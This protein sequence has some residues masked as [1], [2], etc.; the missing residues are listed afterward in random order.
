M[1]LNL[2]VAAQSG[3]LTVSIEI[4]GLEDVTIEPSV[5]PVT[6]EPRAFEL[7]FRERTD[8][9]M[10][11]GVID[12]LTVETGD[13]TEVWLSLE[14]T[15]G[16]SLVDDEAVLVTLVPDSADIAANEAARVMLSA[17]QPSTIVTLEVGDDASSASVFATIE[18][19]SVN[20][21]LPLPNVEPS[22]DSL[23]AELSVTVPRRQFRL[24]FDPS[25]VTLKS[26]D[27][28]NLDISI[29]ALDAESA[30]VAGES[31]NVIFAYNG[32]PITPPQP[33]ILT[34][35]EL[36]VPVSNLQLNSIESGTLTASA[37]LAG[38]DIAEG[39]VGITIER[40]EFR[41]SFTPSVVTVRGGNAFDVVLSLET[42]AG[43]L[44]DGDVV[45][46]TL[47]SDNTAQVW[48][49]DA[50]I[51]LVRDPLNPV[52]ELT[53]MIRVNTSPQVE[54][55]RDIVQF[56]AE[57]I[58][59]GGIFESIP[60][61]VNIDKRE[62]NIAFSPADRLT[63]EAS[64]SANLGLTLS[65]VGGSQLFD[66][67]VTARLSVQDSNGAVIETIVVEPDR[68][69]LALDSAREFTINVPADIE[70]GIGNRFALHVG[71]RNIATN[72]LIEGM[73]I[74]GD[75]ESV[76]I[77]SPFDV[78]W[79]NLPVFEVNRSM[80]NLVFNPMTV[81]VE[82]GGGTE[83]VIVSLSDVSLANGREVTVDFTL[84]LAMGV[85]V[86]TATD[87]DLNDDQI[88]VVLNESQPTAEVTIGA[89]ST[90]TDPHN[91]LIT[92]SVS[93]EAIQALNSLI[94][95]GA[96]QVTVSSSSPPI[97]AGFNSV[98]NPN[99]LS[100]TAGEVE[101]ISLSLEGVTPPL[102][103]PVT[104]SLQISGAD[105]AV[106]RR[107]VSLSANQVVFE[108]D[109]TTAMFDLITQTG[110]QEQSFLIT[111]VADNVGVPISTL[112]VS[113]QLRNFELAFEPQSVEIIAGD[114]TEV[115]LLLSQSL[116]AGESVT[117]VLTVDDIGVRVIPE[118]VVIVG[119]GDPAIPVQ[120]F[121]DSVKQ[122]SGQY[123]VSAEVI[124]DSAEAVSGRFTSRDLPVQVNKRNID[125]MFNSE[126][127]R[128]VRGGVAP[129]SVTMSVVIESVPSLLNASLLEGSETVQAR[130][131]IGS[132]SGLTVTP[133]NVGLSE[134]IP[135]ATVAITADLNSISGVVNV[136][137]G[138]NDNLRNV[139][140]CGMEELCDSLDVE[141]V[142]AVFLQFGIII[143]GERTD[144]LP[145]PSARS[146]ISL[147]EPVE[148]V[149]S[150]GN[151]IATW[152]GDSSRVLAQQQQEIPHRVVQASETAGVYIVA[153]PPLM[154]TESITLIV[155]LS[156][157][158]SIGDAE[159]ARQRLLSGEAI[160]TTVQVTL[161]AMM[162]ETTVEFT[163]IDPDEDSGTVTARVI[164]ADNVAVTNPDGTGGPLEFTLLTLETTPADE[165]ELLFVPSSPLFSLS[166]G[167]S[168]L[169]TVRSFPAL[170]GDQSILATLTLRDSNGLNLVDNVTTQVS[171]VLNASN[172]TEEVNVIAGLSAETSLIYVEVQSNGIDVQLRSSVFETEAMASSNSQ[173]IDVSA[174]SAF[175]V[176][177]NRDLNL[178]FSSE[179]ADSL[180]RLVVPRGSSRV[181]V[182]S[183]EGGRLLN[184]EQLPVTLAADLSG[185]KV[186]IDKD[187]LQD[188]VFTPAMMST[189]I[190]ITAALDATA[191]DAPVELTA[192]F[193]ALQANIDD[194]IQTSLGG[195]AIL[196][197]QPG[198]R[199]F[200]LILE[201]HNIA[202]DA[203][204]GDRR[205]MV[206][207][208]VTETITLLL[209]GSDGA[210][211]ESGEEVEVSLTLA[212]MAGI[213]L[214]GMVEVMPSPIIFNQDQTSAEV[215]IKVYEPQ[216]LLLTAEVIDQ[217]MLP[218]DVQ[219]N[220][221]TLNVMVQRGV[222][223]RFS[224]QP[225]DIQQGDSAILM[226]MIDPI[227]LLKPSNP[228]AVFKPRVSVTLQD[229]V[230][231]R[232]WV[233]RP[234]EV[235][236]MRHRFRLLDAVHFEYPTAA[237]PM[238]IWAAR[239]AM[240]GE[241]V[242][243]ADM[244]AEEGPFAGLFSDRVSGIVRYERPI[245][246]I[247]LVRVVTP[248]TTV[249]VDGDRDIRE[250]ILVKD[251]PREVLLS[252]SFELTGSQTATLD[253]NIEGS[254]LEVSPSVVMFS[255][256]NK[257]STVIMLATE[258]NFSDGISGVLTI[259]ATSGVDLEDDGRFD[260]QVLPQATVVFNPS[261]ITLI[262]GSSP[263]ATVQVATDP[264]L[265][266]VGRQ[267][268]ELLLDVSGV[269]GL[270]LSEDTAVDAIKATTITVTLDA[271][272]TAVNVALHVARYI[273]P[274]T[275]M[276]T[277]E[278]LGEIIDIADGKDIVAGDGLRADLVRPTF[279]L[280]FNNGADSLAVTANSSAP[281][282]VGI[283]P[284]DG[285]PLRAGE[286]VEVRLS[287]GTASIGLTVSPE[288]I[289]FT[290]SRLDLMS[291]Y[292]SAAVEPR[293]SQLSEEV[294]LEADYK[295][296]DDELTAEVVLDEAMQVALNATFIPVTVPILI[297]PRPYVLEFDPT[298]ITL[299]AGVDVV[300]VVIS[301]VGEVPFDPNEGIDVLFTFQDAYGVDHPLNNPTLTENPIR[302]LDPLSGNNLN[303]LARLDHV[304]MQ[305]TIRLDAQLDA[306]SGTLT[307]EAGAGQ[308]SNA[309]FTVAELTVI[310][311]RIFNID[312]VSGDLG[313][314]TV[315]ADGG[316]V[317]E[318]TA[319]SS[320]PVWVVYDGA[321][322][323][324]DSEEVTI[325]LGV[326]NDSGVTISL[327]Q[328]TLSRNTP[329]VEVVLG[330]ELI[331]N[332]LNVALTL[333]LGSHNVDG[334][335]FILSSE[336]IAVQPREFEVVFTPDPLN[337]ISEHSNTVAVSLNALTGRGLVSGDE[338]TLSISIAGDDWT[339]SPLEVSLTQSNPDATLTISAGSRASGVAMLTVEVSQ[340]ELSDGTTALGAAGVVS[341]GLVEIAAPGVLT[342]NLSAR[343][344][345]M[346][347]EPMM[348]DLVRGSP[349]ENTR[350][351]TVSVCAVIL[352]SPTDECESM[353]RPALF[354]DEEITVALVGSSGIT[355]MP[356][357]FMF[358]QDIDNQTTTITVIAEDTVSASPTAEGSLSF[359]AINEVIGSA[360]SAEVVFGSPLIVRV[361]RGVELV[362]STTTNPLTVAAGETTA[363][364]ITT[365]PPLDIAESVTAVL[366]VNGE[367][368]YLIDPTNGATTS[369][370]V[371]LTSAS[372]TAVFQLRVGKPDITG[373]IIAE[374]S[375]AN[376]IGVGIINRN[377]SLGVEVTAPSTVTIVFH[378]SDTGFSLINPRASTTIFIPQG[379]AANAIVT[380]WALLSEVGTGNGAQAVQ[381]V[382]QDTLLSGGGRLQIRAIDD[383]METVG[384]SALLFLNVR[385]G[386]INHDYLRGRIDFPQSQLITIYA[387]RDVP[388]GPVDP[389]MHDP[390]SA[391]VT[392]MVNIDLAVLSPLR[393][394]IVTP[395]AVVFED[396]NNNEI[397]NVE[398]RFGQSMVVNL[399][400]DPP[401]QGREVLLTLA[402]EGVGLDSII[403]L[404]DDNG[405]QVSVLQRMTSDSRSSVRIVV[406][407]RQVPANSVMG[408]LTADGTGSEKRQIIN[409]PSELQLRVLEQVGIVFNPSAVNVIAGGESVTVDITTDALLENNESVELML[410]PPSGII[411]S[412]TVVTLNRDTQEAE[413]IVRADRSVIPASFTIVARADT[414]SPDTREVVVLDG[415]FD[416]VVGQA[417]FD[418]LFNDLAQSTISVIAGESTDVTVSIMGNGNLAAGE[419]V[420]VFL[421]DDINPSE[422]LDTNDT[423][424]LG[425]QASSNPIR[426]DGST[427]EMNVR[428]TVAPDHPNTNGEVVTVRVTIDSTDPHN[429]GGEPQFIDGVIRVAIVERPFTL[430][431]DQAAVSVR[432][433]NSVDVRLSLEGARLASGEAA[434]PVFTLDPPVPGVVPLAVPTTF[435]QASDPADIT[436]LTITL[437]IPADTNP[438]ETRVI[439]SLGNQA[440]LHLTQNIQAELTLTIDS[441]EF[442]LVFVP[443]DISVAASGSATAELRLDGDALSDSEVVEVDL[444]FVPPAE[445]LAIGTPDI[446]FR[447]NERIVSVEITATSATQSGQSYIL[448]ANISNAADLHIA[449]T[450]AVATIAVRP[451]FALSFASP[452]ELIS[453]GN[454]VVA[455]LSLA[456]PLS[457]VGGSLN[458]EFI[459]ETVAPLQVTV[460]PS[461][462]TFT[463]SSTRVDVELSATD[464]AMVQSVILR[465]RTATN[466]VFSDPSPSIRVVRGVDL[467]LANGRTMLIIEA[468]NP[469]TVDVMTQL[470]ES[471]Q[472][473]AL[474][475]AETVTVEL[476]A[477]SPLQ[478]LD[479]NMNP[480]TMKTVILSVAQQST[481][482][483]IFMNAPA[484]SGI[485][486]AVVIDQNDIAVVEGARG[487]ELRLPVESR[488]AAKIEVINIPA[489]PR[490]IAGDSLDITFTTQP[491]LAS[492]QGVGVTLF[493]RDLLG[494]T[495]NR[496]RD[497]GITN[498][499]AA[500]L[501]EVFLG[502][503]DF[504]G[505]IHT[506]STEL[507]IVSSS[508][509][510]R[511]LV[512]LL[513]RE[514]DTAGL[515]AVLTRGGVSYHTGTITEATLSEFQIE[516]IHAFEI[517]FNAPSLNLTAGS[518]VTM[519]ISLVG[520]NPLMPA[521]MVTARLSLNQQGSGVSIDQDRVVF[522]PGATMTEVTVSAS[523]DVL[524]S[525][526]ALTVAVAIN[527]LLNQPDQPEFTTIAPTE[528][529][530]I[531]TPR[532]FNLG[533]ELNPPTASTLIVTAYDS[534]RMDN[535]I[536][537]VRVS[538]V[539]SG[540]STFNTANNESVTI[541]FMSGNDQVK[542]LPMTSDCAADN[543][544]GYTVDFSAN[545]LDEIVQVCADEQLVPDQELTLQGVVRSG[546]VNL[547]INSAL[548]PLEV[549]AL[550]DFSINFVANPPPGKVRAGDIVTVGVSLEG[551][552]RDGTPAVLQ[553][554][555]QVTVTFVVQPPL[556]GVMLSTDKLG[557][558]SDSMDGQV[559]LSVIS[560]VR[561][562]FELR[563]ELNQSEV[564]LGYGAAL[565]DEDSMLWT[566][567][568]TLTQ[569]QI[570][571]AVVPTFEIELRKL[572]LMFDR[573]TLDL[574]EGESA[575]VGI[576][577]EGANLSA[578]EIIP[579]RFES[580]PRGAVTA[581]A[582]I[583]MTNAV[584]M[585][586]VSNEENLEGPAYNL[587]GLIDNILDETESLIASVETDPLVEPIRLTVTLKPR[588]FKLMFSELS[589]PIS[590]TRPVNV[591]LSLMSESVML[592]GRE[593]VSLLESGESVTVALSGIDT[594]AA[595][596]DAYIEVQPS[597][598]TL[599]G[600][601]TDA[602][603]SAELEL[604]VT[605]ADIRSVQLIAT[606]MDAVTEG[607]VYVAE[608]SLE[609]TPM[610]RVFV[611]KFMPSQ[612]VLTPASESSY[613]SVRLSLTPSDISLVGGEEVK[614][615][616]LNYVPAFN[617]LGLRIL[618][619]A[620][621]EIDPSELS[622]TPGMESMELKVVLMAATRTAITSSDLVR[623]SIEITEKTP[624]SLMVLTNEDSS[625][626]VNVV[627][628]DRQ[629]EFTSTFT[630][631][632]NTGMPRLSLRQGA[633]KTI[634][635]LSQGVATLVGDEEVVFGVSPASLAAL[636]SNNIRVVPTRSTVTAIS[637]AVFE[638]VAGQNASSEVLSFIVVSSKLTPD[639]DVLELSSISID[640]LEERIFGLSFNPLDSIDVVEGSSKQ[641]KVSLNGIDGSR[642]FEGEVVTARLTVVA[643]DLD[644]SSDVSLSV[645]E[646]VPFEVVNDFYELGLS[647][648]EPS[649]FVIVNAPSG[650][651]SATISA[652][653]V[654]SDEGVEFADANARIERSVLPITLAVNILEPGSD[655]NLVFTPPT[656]AIVIAGSTAEIAVAL[657][658]ID[659]SILRPGENVVIEARDSGLSG[660]S[661]TPDSI[662]LDSSN[663]SG[664]FTV[665]ATRDV[666]GI[667][668]PDFGVQISSTSLNVNL[669]SLPI[670]QVVPP[671]VQFRAQLTRHEDDL[672]SNDGLQLA[673]GSSATLIIS[674]IDVG[675]LNEGEVVTIAV[676]G[677]SGTIEI[678]NPLNQTRAN[679]MEF[680]LSRAS[681]EIDVPVYV[682]DTAPVGMVSL[683]VSGQSSNFIFR[684]VGTVPTIEIVEQRMFNIVI[685]PS[686]SGIEGIVE[687]SLEGLN[688]R[689]IGN[690][691]VEVILEADEEGKATTFEPPSLMFTSATIYRNVDI[692]VAANA[693]MNF[694]IRAKAVQMPANTLVEEGVFTVTVDR[695]IFVLAFRQATDVY[696]R[697]ETVNSVTTRAGDPVQ[698]LL[699]LEGAALADGEIVPVRVTAQPGQANINGEG[700]MSR[701]MLTA[702]YPSTVVT[703]NSAFDSGS[704]FE[705]EA[706]VESADIPDAL[707]AIPNSNIDAIQGTA[708][709]VNIER[710]FRLVFEPAA[711][712]VTAG[713]SAEVRLLLQLIEGNLAGDETVIVNLPTDNTQ[714]VWTNVSPITF[715][716][717]EM[718]TSITV[719][720]TRVVELGQPDAIFDS[721]PLDIPGVT[722]DLAHLA[723]NIVKREFEISF[724]P[725]DTLTVTAGS[726]ARLALTLNGVEGSQ[727]FDNERVTA[728][729]TVV[730]SEGNFVNVIIA[731]PE[732]SVSIP[733]GGGSTLEVLPLTL[734]VAGAFIIEAAVDAP[735]GMANSFKLAL[736][737]DDGS[738][739]IIDT[740]DVTP[741]SLP[742]LEVV[743][744]EFNLVFNLS[745]LIV[746]AG[747]SVPIE[748][749][750]E[751]GNSTSDLGADILAVTLSFN[752]VN[753][754]VVELTAASPSAEF[755][756]NI[757]A[758]AAMEGILTATAAALTNANITDT[759]LPVTIAG[760]AFALVFR[761]L[762][763]AE[764][765]DPQR[766]DQIVLR[767]GRSTQVWLSL[768]DADLLADESVTVTLTADESVTATSTADAIVF[769]PS[770]TSALV[771]I[772]ANLDATDAYVL[773]LIDTTDASMPIPP[774]ASFAD[775]RLDIDVLALAL[776]FDRAAVELTVDEETQ[777]ELSLIDVEG[778]ALARETT[779]TVQ[780]STLEGVLVSPETV[781]LSGE[782]PSV[783]ISLT[784]S[785][786][787][788]EGVLTA[789]VSAGADGVAIRDG[790]L[791]VGV[792]S[793]EFE[794]VFRSVS[795]TAREAAPLT[796]VDILAAGTT[797]VLLSLE[798]AEFADGE[799]VT[800]RVTSADGL[801]VPVDG[802]EVML[803]ATQTMVVVEL[804]AAFNAVN[805]T[806]TAAIDP[807]DYVPAGQFILPP[808]ANFAMATVDA[809]IAL[810][811][812]TLA[813]N[814]ST[815]LR[816][817]AGDSAVVRL[818]LQAVEGSMLGESMLGEGEQVSVDLTYQT[819]LVGGELSV[820]PSP[821]AVTLTSENLSA[822]II[823]NASAMAS[824][825]NL[826]ASASVMNANIPDA[827]IPVAIAPRQLALV[828]NPMSVAFD[829]ESADTV[830]EISLSGDDISLL[831]EDES[832][833]VTLTADADGVTI[834]PPTLTLR[835][836]VASSVR[837]QASADMRARTLTAT[838]ATLINANI[839]DAALPMTI[840]ERQFAL[841][842][843]S[844]TMTEQGNPQQIDQVELRE[845]QSIQVWLS[846]EGSR[847]L[848]GEFATARLTV[849][850][851]VTVTLP[852]D[853][854]EDDGIIF[855]AS[856]TSAIVTL[857]ANPDATDSYVMASVSTT[858]AQRMPI[859]PNASFADARLDIDVLALALAFDRA[860][861]ELT[862]D[863]ETQVELSLIDVEGSALARETTI[864]V[865]LSTLEGVLVSPE[866][867]ILSGEN[868]ST[869][870]SLTALFNAV[871]GVLTATVSAGAG[872]LAI[873]DGELSVG[874]T[875]RAFELV[876]RSV[877]DTARETAPLTTVNILA[878][879]TTQVL[880]SL[881]GAE[882]ADD[883]EVTV[884]ITS[885]DGLIAP[886]D[887]TAVLLSAT[888]TMVVVELNAAFNAVNTPVTAAIDP[889]D[890]V[891]DGQ[892]ILPPNANF[893]MATVD[894]MIALREFTLVFQSINRAACVGRRFSGGEVNATSCGRFNAWRVNAWRR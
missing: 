111:A 42:L 811:E 640:I 657:E 196:S 845:G 802:T 13:S 366:K 6:I 818:T 213:S 877:S 145:P 880:L 791:S 54:T 590:L 694:S 50:T 627:P 425:I 758:D 864:T 114:S 731:T 290:E 715:S 428:L 588:Q 331:P 756:F 355:S 652:D 21:Q 583:E 713:N 203:D 38:A 286:M 199:E 44:L 736:G 275:G 3:T 192:S 738:G 577:L 363:I 750:I 109:M 79:G 325:D 829:P 57:A 322:F 581:Q 208:S 479:E 699:S 136:L 89:A 198:G 774:N 810:R 559:E 237:Q 820:T 704:S 748:I 333:T 888:Q 267:R 689:L 633:T 130:A 666:A 62:F 872:G 157:G 477:T 186:A 19:G 775:A 245:D 465:P 683:Q 329:M 67:I 16:G 469:Q 403:Q 209:R 358:D 870:L 821:M 335:D 324:N 541:E 296:E 600:N 113:I 762:T 360:N 380:T 379:F 490:L 276:I 262:A 726:M 265:E 260:V 337:V 658:G 266:I 593:V 424:V 91:E 158:L 790:E 558:T 149:I 431:F 166:Q 10:P 596:S 312:I 696:R 680:D 595:G 365:N 721:R 459:L 304:S 146:Q 832:V 128:L 167:E 781:I 37:T 493:Q 357:D 695:R 874:V 603:L 470:R 376:D 709:T 777:V 516:V 401:L 580:V 124:P 375:D 730:D 481:E 782:N 800:V 202:I 364:E 171:A 165:V 231:K 80:G 585:F 39:A 181:V 73:Q 212:P 316:G 780:L 407:D 454:P 99:A 806:V 453:G 812:F 849:D 373:E 852:A 735:L 836:S 569:P 432:G 63:V 173:L 503:D 77:S 36:N 701:V 693:L 396:I 217:T 377:A 284:V 417:R 572:A 251:V 505:Q 480:V 863:E 574:F 882:F 467:L 268:A 654:D 700:R 254:G 56:T 183:L 211:L 334:G 317:L 586:T 560:N 515:G 132:G 625:L 97:V 525:P 792:T 423:R 776:V 134:S 406:V 871:E 108:G 598:V 681:A 343:R 670:I 300:D 769:S 318:V 32:V 303:A 383:D 571:A 562:S 187:L 426:L 142:R 867:V 751:P 179:I 554:G 246:V 618:S 278:V 604:T 263:V 236:E 857:T 663:L 81:V 411:L 886:A 182:L 226:I 891:P 626:T 512:S 573:L 361:V 259:Q 350:E 668:V 232:I 252:L 717:A 511:G 855:S 570:V 106:S 78:H 842:F 768:E 757:P 309:V 434:I 314:A 341:H 156:S 299:L 408:L 823:V 384:N 238:E 710:Q 539:A 797:Q 524:I 702:A 352:N 501:V 351:V 620:D 223:V 68:L 785:F 90:A 404:V 150:D 410:T 393:I 621:V 760:R 1:N 804:N 105:D 174:E 119:G 456:G 195:P 833:V 809:M 253:V 60:L 201:S 436:D 194:R 685:V 601:G 378:P 527:E 277:V 336:S 302:V 141:V 241:I 688:T 191:Q 31:V 86:E 819:I 224:P 763:T 110:A 61:V 332:E 749:S 484:Q 885:A 228:D 69:E 418:L 272:T 460:T 714:P 353:P 14:G 697:G 392:G 225:L 837:I 45:V 614:I 517:V 270:L 478:I 624:D 679:R 746:T 468:G 881:E 374:V 274:T 647:A 784:A 826:M 789:T 703:I 98:F 75:A 58:L 107:Q 537:T 140:V 147:V 313:A 591:S 27:E 824:G 129:S 463:A 584:S 629:F 222:V 159:T 394:E 9:G 544:A 498:E 301:I 543:L 794:L 70:L 793:R 831:G 557:L 722:F 563:I 170:G 639:A 356:I 430:A 860:A 894:A 450:S 153:N 650:A 545:K 197:I 565:V 283:T 805:T 372:P 244:Q 745:E 677:D 846:L 101:T 234:A 787:V 628:A 188:I 88:Q 817:L 214:D 691:S 29:Q 269:A 635:L 466:E 311:S 547:D 752:G 427:P 416:V 94:S 405:N 257:V 889:N 796:T 323:A 112:P 706:T 345:A 862:V 779:I 163:V 292:E 552:F 4:P 12:S 839:A 765:G 589:L 369:Q 127:I 808:N 662:T 66:E 429:L 305:T 613:Q 532:V 523:F 519:T 850:E 739:T 455:E 612:V 472:Q 420:P 755:T 104:V 522:T 642:L 382:L 807:N 328:V 803:S 242:T 219:V 367:E 610:D 566:V 41:L 890:Y 76:F 492:D 340:F 342:V 690:E 250:L 876:F 883:E 605:S 87:P 359:P 102:M 447:Q 667:G 659:G 307:A 138:S 879:G 84:L 732:P 518:S 51:E 474:R 177:V 26:G 483:Q 841:A 549:K 273:Q 239:D 727:L 289:S 859:P 122:P 848:D 172:R 125:L 440:A 344:V 606:A 185:G 381:V 692:D 207:A 409:L 708:L 816:V 471:G 2:P 461:S 608:T 143:G 873:R 413:I 534:R 449:E 464:A 264:L 724:S 822:E 754:T 632:Q 637:S 674:L 221:G 55:M 206:I 496:A 190:I 737:G 786:D 617:D 414:N 33:V 402:I 152:V 442:N 28:L 399:R 893:A 22:L 285:V 673:R 528:L 370:T 533:F 348:I 599:T 510:Q 602:N 180:N 7:V 338:V 485:L 200:N 282:L 240:I 433:G 210:L 390:F 85:F 844:L 856:R 100:L 308:V 747:D 698:V 116:D 451:P 675:V 218:R 25:R 521:D 740:F 778:S 664:V 8:E 248:K 771:T 115:R 320:T 866:T 742:A 421:V 229:A 40:R 619:S 827:A 462:F 744:R 117:V 72:E 536:S 535:G 227:D 655:F 718:S 96:L 482:V 164:S 733:I 835:G 529:A 567:G 446:L 488:G 772:T 133:S 550:R 139:F 851:S 249:I 438:Q 723:V 734:G 834:N 306:V 506:N 385:L 676:S 398:F 347:F 643:N 391:R 178:V 279:S 135:A 495:L 711:V 531:P 422:R 310:V 753:Q 349:N 126:S 645:D 597:Q 587:R 712:T 233:L 193:G 499:L 20:P 184:N 168:K 148:P 475:D 388:I 795:D 656:T 47:P 23:E 161:T 103:N 448:R 473:S 82:P 687:L 368:M 169:L 854:G 514:G 205:L 767:A 415:G 256:T 371:H 561:G 801:I 243:L 487:N 843:R 131:V 520:N 389:L 513:T 868:P 609:V 825:G 321:Q 330:A 491:L 118:Q 48:T 288:G 95:D 443:Q 858:D 64:S 216:S 120:I 631:A 59:E 540:G 728:Q 669:A 865:Q 52:A 155:A 648:S 220:N 151:N 452:V 486:T 261:P 743:A 530:I 204:S 813:F 773:A 18:P 759:M 798:G 502:Y 34:V 783:Q 582:T 489:Q 623:T 235:G 716:N 362:F 346:R 651:T 504:N 457:D 840:G 875:P 542:V 555:E 672:A 419:V 616:L 5:L 861:V 17:S 439:V 665:S 294:T 387:S 799:T 705:V 121:G 230:E 395:R 720:T 137:Q 576:S 644:G 315:G 287:T 92:A 354:G 678:E 649:A 847:L 830:V 319:G 815:E 575:M 494:I 526:V 508:D 636:E 93:L 764:Q 175:A 607:A 579:I 546:N 556:D 295:A 65:G 400:L 189:S 291:L 814:P 162:L 30:L 35:D 766:I 46:V 297:T 551:R 761:G 682:A 71:G 553:P 892:F 611:P 476:T 435:S 538:L 641:L 725:S 412:E 293:L 578:G 339:V 497:P 719:R 445:G 43:A 615:N 271:N 154:G 247:T 630:G 564:V 144:L 741:D 441:R 327:Q 509:A 49:D 622:F 444:S 280:N 887:S 634:E 853:A 160:E 671:T 215:R 729:V 123:R 437:D 24:V 281:V 568:G 15:N 878:A 661:I 594:G 638:I 788:V 386:G 660:A 500:E 646:G 397:D 869:N 507:T 458:V 176:F 74:S 53:T 11:G 707:T 884:R 684:D 548:L 83:Q 298:S 828:F 653:I 838:A 592:N 255:A 686:R 258:T 770:R 326:Q